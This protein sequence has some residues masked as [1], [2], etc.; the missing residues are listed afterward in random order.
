M[1]Y[2]VSHT[3]FDNAMN[4]GVH[5]A[6]CPPIHPFSTL[7]FAFFPISSDQFTFN[8]HFR[9][10]TGLA[11]HKIRCVICIKRIRQ[12]R[13]EDEVRVE[14]DGVAVMTDNFGAAGWDV[15]EWLAVVCLWLVS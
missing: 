15:G 7:Y 14:A 2:S 12:M 5:G 9:S 4:V 13:E 8:L 10:I 11:S 6:F 1:P 3:P